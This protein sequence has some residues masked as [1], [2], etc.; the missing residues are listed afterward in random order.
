MGRQALD[1]LEC[2]LQKTEEGCKSAP[3]LPDPNEMWDPGQQHRPLSAW[4]AQVL[5]GAHRR[6]L[7]ILLAGPCLLSSGRPWCLQAARRLCCAILTTVA[8]A[9]RC[10]K[11]F[12]SERAFCTV[13]ILRECIARMYV[14][15]DYI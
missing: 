5:Y 4:W 12:S 7:T 10:R 8:S 3:G 13:K 1:R 6:L 14:Y 9:P 2:H 11:I 15:V